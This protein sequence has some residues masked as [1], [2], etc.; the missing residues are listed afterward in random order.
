[1]A[2]QVERDPQV[3]TVSRILRVLFARA[4][5]IEAERVGY[6][7]KRF[8]LFLQPSLYRYLGLRCRTAD[9]TAKAAQR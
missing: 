5:F 7:L 9:E 8:V 2:Q 6:P 3:M 4:F 1:V